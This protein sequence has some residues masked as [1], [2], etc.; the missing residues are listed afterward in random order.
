MPTQIHGTVVSWAAQLIAKGI[1]V[2]AWGPNALRLV[3]EG[4][5]EGFMA[6][7]EGM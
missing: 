6:Q 4:R 7:Y 5:L 3:S 2:G 1:E